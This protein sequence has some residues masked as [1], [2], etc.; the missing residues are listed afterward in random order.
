MTDTWTLV[1]SDPEPLAADATRRDR[2]LY[3]FLRRLRPGFRHVYAMRPAGRFKGWIVANWHS[4]RLDLIEVPAD[5]P[6][7]IGPHRFESY[8]AYIWHACEQGLAHA[9][10]VEARDGRTWH[11]RGGATCVTAMK[12]LLGIPAPGVFTPWQLYRHL[13]PDL[14]RSRTVDNWLHRHLT[15][16]E[17]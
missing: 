3:G 17:P 6:V 1:F 8:G 15:K 9:V 2:V 14:F 4:G 13:N 10:P 16:G 12:H 11:P 7:D 5:E